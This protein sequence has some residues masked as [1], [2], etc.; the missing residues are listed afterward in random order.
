MIVISEVDAFS[1]P[2]AN[3]SS[4]ALVERTQLVFTLFASK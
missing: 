4:F 2:L 3:I 1:I